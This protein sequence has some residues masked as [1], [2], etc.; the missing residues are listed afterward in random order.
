MCQQECFQGSVEES[1]TTSPERSKAPMKH[2]VQ[3]TQDDLI[4][5]IKEKLS[6]EGRKVIPREFTIEF[7]SSSSG[8]SALIT[9]VV[10]EVEK[11]PGKTPSTA[12]TAA[13]I[14]GGSGGV[15]DR[16]EALEQASAPNG[17]R[18]AGRGR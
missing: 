9:G 15:M 8:T 7:V 12:Q 5:L 10:Q 16:S 17:R 18:R 13:D 1:I 14:L 6:E 2:V 11:A 4:E 3:F